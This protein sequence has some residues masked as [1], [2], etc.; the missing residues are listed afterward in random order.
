M[1]QTIGISGIIYSAIA[2]IG[3]LSQYTVLKDHKTL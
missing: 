1:Y 2:S 3:L